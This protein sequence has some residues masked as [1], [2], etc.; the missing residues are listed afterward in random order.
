MANAARPFRLLSL[1]FAS[2]LATAP[3]P[4]FAADD[5]TTGIIAGLGLTAASGKIT[6]GASAG[7]IEAGL[8]NSESFQQTGAIIAG[9]VNGLAPGKRVL[10]LAHDEK[11]DLIMSQVVAD[12]IED[13]QQYVVYNCAHLPSPK[14]AHVAVPTHG[15][16]DFAFNVFGP[17][18]GELDGADLAGA[19]MVDTTIGGV[20][21]TA[22]DRLLISSLLM[23]K[24]QS[25]LPLAAV[26]TPWA[27]PT[28]H[29][30]TTTYRSPAD[31]IGIDPQGKIYPAYREFVQVINHARLTCGGDTGKAI[32][33]VGDGL[34]TSLNASDKGP[35]PLAT[36]IQTEALGRG[37]PL[38][39]RL[40]IEQVGGTSLSRTGIGYSFGWPNAATVGA[41]LL[42]SFRLI[43]PAAGSVMAMGLVRCMVRQ[44][45]IKK[46]A[47]LLETAPGQPRS[48]GAKALGEVVCD[49]KAT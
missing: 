22:D 32:M 37:S 36:A 20:A 6:L 45:N 48:S 42:A 34:I 19:A 21:L 13:V 39:L 12:R 44:T 47:D 7:A 9:V 26:W 3:V 41:G 1:L 2:A 49:Y 5:M 10:V 11:L 8:L 25:A 43:D 31:A 46:V 24:T 40:A 30:G 28:G 14:P 33:G 38:V 23:Q 27:H 18:K 16:N 29:G 35:A 4:T 15:L 17:M